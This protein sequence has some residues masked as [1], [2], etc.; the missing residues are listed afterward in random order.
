MSF[1]EFCSVL[2][3]YSS[4][5]PLIEINRTFANICI[6]SHSMQKEFAIIKKIKK[7][8]GF[9]VLKVSRVFYKFSQVFLVRFPQS[10]IEKKNNFKMARTQK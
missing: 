3:F 6:N 4:A 1:V 5:N 10:Q 2:K 9:L 8:K 7:K